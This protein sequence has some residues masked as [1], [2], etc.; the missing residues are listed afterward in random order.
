MI[1]KYQQRGQFRPPFSTTNSHEKEKSRKHPASLEALQMREN[2]AP[3]LFNHPRITIQSLPAP[4]PIQE[5]TRSL[6][7]RAQEETKALTILQSEQWRRGTL[8]PLTSLPALQLR[9]VPSKRPPQRKKIILVASII[10]VLLLA[11]ACFLWISLS[12]TTPDVTLYQVSEHN[13][14]QYSGG[15]G[16]VFPRQKFTLSY[17]ELEYAVNVLVKVGD[18]VSINQPLIKLD[19]TKL[20]AQI[21]Q[22]SDDVAAAQAYLSSVA[23]SGNADTIAHAQQQYTLANNKYNAL[24]AESSSLLLHNGNLISPMNGVITDI[25]VNSGEIFAPDTPLLVIMDESTVIVH[26]QVPLANLSQIHTGEQAIVTPSALPDLNFQGT[27]SSIVP[28]ADP[29]T[30]TFEVLVNV[31]NPQ[32]KLLPGMSTFVRIQATGQALVVPRLAILNPSEVPV[33][34]VVRDQYAYLQPVHI[35][36]LIGDCVLVHD[37]LKVGDRVVLVGQ[38]TL[39]NGQ[40]VHIRSTEI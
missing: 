36:A 30:D 38:S 3:T 22:Q 9:S 7:Q 6:L 15:G 29:Q 14:T 35:E 40:H 31:P 33:T 4:Q 32:T 39:Y 1:N 5:Q 17:P 21:K 23:A 37:G 19:P 18:Q 11:I 26:V 24:V 27:I 10:T 34:F 25:E 12:S 8:L 2:D 16:I 28:Q 13:I 20:N